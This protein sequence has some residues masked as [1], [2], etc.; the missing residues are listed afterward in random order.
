[1]ADLLLFAEFYDLKELS[2]FV[3][4]GLF[5]FFITNFCYFPVY[6]FFF[7]KDLFFSLKIFLCDPVFDIDFLD[8]DWAF[9]FYILNFGS[10]ISCYKVNLRS[11][12]EFN[13]EKLFYECLDIFYLLYT[14]FIYLFLS[15]IFGGKY[16]YYFY[17]FEFLYS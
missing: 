13:V 14:F 5:E 6:I 3:L 11:G 8:F 2:K 1:L 15:Y 7:D 9:L 4:M 17:T 16:F 12:L 10:R